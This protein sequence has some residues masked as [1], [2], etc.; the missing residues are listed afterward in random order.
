[1][2]ICFLLYSVDDYTTLTP[3]PNELLFSPAQSQQLRTVTILI[4]N[5]DTHEEVEQFTVQLSLPSNSTG[6]I[7][8][9]DSATVH[10]VDEDSELKCVVS[11]CHYVYAHPLQE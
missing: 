7:L 4:I 1:M 10:I 11:T 8:D 5:D 6:V 3:E 2:Y 9:Q